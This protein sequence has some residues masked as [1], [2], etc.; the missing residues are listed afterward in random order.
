MAH[1][2]LQIAD[3]RRVGGH[4]FVRVLRSD[5]RD[6]LALGAFAGDEKRLPGF[7]TFQRI[8]FSIQPQLV[9]LFVGPVTFVAALDENGLNISS[10]I[11][12]RLLACKKLWGK[13]PEYR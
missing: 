8:R 10:K 7:A 12:L 6:E 5:P 4:H 1:G 3:S 2:K 9:L 11:N 13:Q